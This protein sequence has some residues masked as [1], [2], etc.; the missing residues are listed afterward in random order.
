MN[1]SLGQT[2]S[3][4][5]SLPAFN[6]VV[7]DPAGVTLATDVVT[8]GTLTLTSGSF[9]LSNR[10]L[11]INNPI[12][13]TGTNLV[14][15]ANSSITVAG[16]AA[17]ITLPTSVTLLNNL[18][19]TNTSGLA[20]SMD[21]TIGGTLTLS[22]GPVTDGTATIHIALTGT[23]VRTTGRVVGKLGKTLNTG[24]AVPATFEIGD[25]ARYAPVTLLF[26]SITSTGEI[27][28]STTPGDHPDIANSGLAPTR[29][30]NRWWTLSNAGLLFTT[31][32]ATFTF[33]PADVDPGSTTA[34][35]V[36]GKRDGT[37]WTL[38]PPGTRTATSTQAFGLTSFSEF[39]VGE[40]TVDLA[41]SV[42]D[43]LASVV[44][45]DGVTHAY[46]ITVSNGGLSD[47][48][49]VSLS[50]SWPTGFVQG[51]I[52]PSQGSCTP[53]G[54]GPDFSCALGTIA[55]GGS[56][57]VNVAYTVPADAASGVQTETVS[58]SSAL[59]DADPT[60]DTASDTTTVIELS[61]LTVVKDDGLASAVAGDGLSHAYTVTVSNAGPSDADSVALDDVVPAA[62]TVGTPSADLGGDCTGSLGNTIACALPASLAVGATW[63][64]TVPYTVGPGATPGTVTNTARATSAENP[65]GITGSDATAIVGSGDL[66][67]SVSD[68]LASVVAGDGLTHAYTIIVTNGGPSDA[69][70]VSLTDSWPAAF[71]QGAISP[72]Q[73]SCGPLGAG[74]D[75]SCALGTIAAGGSATVTVEYTVLATAPAG[76][77]TATV[78]VSSVLIDADPTNDTASDTT[79][80]IESSAPGG[81]GQAPETGT[82][83]PAGPT[84]AA[85]SL[86]AALLVV[87]GSFLIAVRRLDRSPDRRHRKS[88][89]ARP[90]R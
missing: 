7:D 85:L 26:A 31:Y 11:T 67:V 39:A 87:C 36:V 33:V 19:V 79:T 62:L 32:D 28:A 86:I 55:A 76:V 43:G 12:A 21:L 9:N 68:G 54:A 37:S 4:S 15:G 23:V 17:G 59:V 88:P 35:F 22:G 83:L 48:T 57:T 44:A 6:L 60:N 64:V 73:G 1:G 74:P 42:S 13:G 52:S 20:V 25:A 49:L 29:S 66:A 77:Q 41:V 40:P 84:T 45:G 27:V 61:A 58:V 51:T 69:T 65:G 8:T 70:L 75:F 14:T 53:I 24:A 3:G 38:T 30:V 2:I 72:S 16:A 63:T 82:L 78:R 81:G 80:V 5:S 10:R 71:S 56:A 46:T 89:R 34:V 47:A 50:D 18:T 90:R